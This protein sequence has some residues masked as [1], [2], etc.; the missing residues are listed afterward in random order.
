MFDSVW[1]ALAVWWVIGCMFAICERWVVTLLI[2]P[3]LLKPANSGVFVSAAFEYGSLVTF[4][5]LL[6]LGVWFNFK[7]SDNWTGMSSDEDDRRNIDDI[8]G[9]PLPEDSGR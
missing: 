6:V 8:L 4:C 7:F 2:S 9:C 5:V 3:T 1:A